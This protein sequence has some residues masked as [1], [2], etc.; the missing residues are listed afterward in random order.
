MRKVPRS[1]KRWLVVVFCLVVVTFLLGYFLTF[2]L[3]GKIEER[4][5][6]ING[7]VSTVKVR[8]LNRSIQLHNVQWSSI[9]DSTHVYPDYI[10]LKHV[11][12][13]GIALLPLLINQRLVIRRVV[14][15]SGR[16][17]FNA[18]NR[19]ENAT[20]EP[21]LRFLRINTFTIRSVQVL[22][23]EDSLTTFSG[24]LEG[25]ISRLIL[26][27]DSIHAPRYSMKA[28]TLAID[29]FQFTPTGGEYTA[30]IQ[31]I[32][33][34]T[35]NR[36]VTLDSMLLIPLYG[37]FEFAQR[38]GEQRGRLNVSI[39]KI[40]VNGWE[41]ERIMEKA[42]M[43]TSIRIHQFDLYSFKDK[44]LPFK[45][46]NV[47]PLPME[48]FATLQLAI[49]IDSVVISNSDVIIE[50]FPETGKASGVISF[51]Q[52]N[53]IITGL[54]NRWKAGDANY[55]ILQANANLMNNGHIQAQFHLPQD[56]STV[57]MAKGSISKVELTNLN[58]AL[59]N[60]ANLRIA[61]GYLQ[62]MT[63]AFRYT[64]YESKGSLDMAYKDLHIIG[65]DKNKSTTNE[66]KTLLIR[67]FTPRD[68]TKS[69]PLSKAVG[70]IDIQRNRQKFIFN[71]W[72]KSILDGIQSSILGNRSMPKRKNQG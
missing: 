4:I 28:A 29:T 5:A 6:L 58:D 53:A 62:D 57:Y 70:S 10:A 7:Q 46:T 14:L 49:K 59:G 34:N 31:Q 9:G 36:Q 55:A 25:E 45:R 18:R 12:I 20:S 51:N 60:M 67:V 35:K 69:V 52:L 19:Q 1:I 37:K 24:H 44:R 48:S 26:E 68:K 64:E 39:P 47:V 22:V 72:W 54:D 3:E 42:F 63:F 15:D 38:L 61:S 65:L 71:V 56:G 21:V 17:S 23:Q 40:M 11:K 32:S 41:W 27:K 30:T 8:L 33:I 13:Q 16:V 2:Y 50:T 43:A 66:L